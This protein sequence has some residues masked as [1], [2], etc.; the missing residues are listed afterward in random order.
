MPPTS[1]ASS[2]AVA[3]ARPASSAAPAAVSA[4]AVRM[5]MVEVELARSGRE[6]PSSA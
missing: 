6:V 1:R 5:E 2:A 4:P 3:A